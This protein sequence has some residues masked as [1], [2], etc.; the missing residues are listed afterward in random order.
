MRIASRPRKLAL[1]ARS[2]TVRDPR[3]E[4]NSGVMLPKRATSDAPMASR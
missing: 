4:L 1:R 3:V 2:A